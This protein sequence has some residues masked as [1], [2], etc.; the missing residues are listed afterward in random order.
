M[1]YM[2]NV[3]L[4]IREEDYE[5]LKEERKNN[6]DLIRLLEMGSEDDSYRKN[7]IIVLSWNDIKWY[8]SFSEIEDVE[9]FM[10]EL[11]KKDAPYKFIRIGEDYDDIEFRSNWG[12]EDKYDREECSTI[13]NAVSL[14]RDIDIYI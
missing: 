4:A 2:S 11:E 10:H 1:S 14:Y 5:L 3:A 9:N 7:G 8:D 6:E 12:D 13:A